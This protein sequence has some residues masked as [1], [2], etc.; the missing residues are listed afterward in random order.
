M[1]RRCERACDRTFPQHV[2]A[3]RPF[4]W[5]QSRRSPFGEDRAVCEVGLDRL[6]S[7][8]CEHDVPR[9]V[10]GEDDGRLLVTQP[11][12]TF[13]TLTSLANWTRQYKDSMTRSSLPS[14]ARLAR[15][16]L[17]SGLQMSTLALALQRRRRWH[18]GLALQMRA[19]LLRLVFR[20]SRAAPL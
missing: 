6:G 1:Q 8:A 15:S 11:N 2:E 7:E 9:R 19:A 14:S 4:R 17:P 5:P 12:G 3:S 20:E 13:L 10:R 16:V 18:S